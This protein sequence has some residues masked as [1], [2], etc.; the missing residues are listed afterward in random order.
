MTSSIFMLLFELETLNLSGS[1]LI[2]ST[3]RCHFTACE[4][5][6][7][8]AGAQNM[9]VCMTFNLPIYLLGQKKTTI[10]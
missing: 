4:K 10:D 7:S 2:C 6:T 1:I 9:K 8:S 3:I 5:Y